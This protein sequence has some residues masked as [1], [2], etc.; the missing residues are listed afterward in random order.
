M[1]KFALQC[2]HCGTVNKASTF[3]LAKKVITCGNCKNEI[4]VKANR[5]A[6]GNCE[7]CGSVAFDQAKGTCPVC[8]RKIIITDSAKATSLEDLEKSDTTPLFLCPD[9]G[10]DIQASKRGNDLFCPVCDYEFNGYEEIFKQIQKSKLVSNNGISVIK[11]EGDNQTFVWKHPI[12]DFNMGSQLIVH[13]SQEAI[14]FLNGQALDL[15]GPGRH[16]LETENLPVLNKVCDLPTGK[17]NPFHAEVYFVNKT[18][19]MGMKWGTSDKV[20]F[21]EPETGIPLEIGASG[22]MNLQVADSRKL[23]VKLVGTT[24]GI[25]WESD[26][27][28]FTQSLRNSFRPLIATTLKT[29]LAATIKSERINILE[30]DERLE[31]LSSALGAKISAGFEEY[32]LSVPQFYVTNVALPEEDKN[33]KKIRELLG[34]SYLG[35]REAEV[36]AEIIKARR[37]KVLEEQA[38]DLERAKF[39]AEK[40]RI[41][42]QAEA[43]EYRF[44]E[45]IKIELRR[46]EGLSEAEIMQAKG[47]NQKDVLQADVQK[48]YAEG[49]G[50]V[51]SNA[52]GGSGG[53]GGSMMSDILSL[54]VGM[55]AMGAMSEKV[56]DVMKGFNSGITSDNAQAS[57]QPV[58]TGWKCS[59]GCEGNTGK[60]CS[61]CGMAKPELWDC[62]SCGAKGN[63]GKFCSE[64]GTAKPELWDCPHCG[65]KGNKGKFC[66]ECGRKREDNE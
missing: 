37:Q 4:D 32:G 59:C 64:C 55:A 47:Y 27:K 16:T 2:P 8:K 56:G 48:A 42:A 6:V 41:A 35:V 3:I 45:G 50:Q 34:A 62:P 53:S 5:M 30:I 28:S 13:E 36:E 11:Y 12:E 14:F 66:S 39:E 24:S 44:K 20:R 40:K 51:G 43:D 61:E 46:Q 18:V 54:G 7:N 49:I 38:T 52:G 19:Q 60:F 10:C 21:I 9:C 58:S 57:Q 31:S 65:A 15:F 29:N 63:K 25:A 1:A 17:Q 33:F 23:L 22:E 26:S